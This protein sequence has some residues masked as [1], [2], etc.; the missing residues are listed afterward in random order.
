MPPVS[1]ARSGRGRSSSSKNSANGR[2]S[3]ASQD[4]E[5]RQ[6]I[7]NLLRTNGVKLIEGK[8]GRIGL[9]FFNF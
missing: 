7:K 3:T 1:S 4:D 9:F 8:E 6:R 2:R 5:P